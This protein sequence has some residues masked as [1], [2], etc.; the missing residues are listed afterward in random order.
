M[1]D[2][3]SFNVQN[4]PTNAQ[5]GEL[6]NLASRGEYC[7]ACLGSGQIANTDEPSPW[8]G[9]LALPPGSDLAVVM[10]FVQ[11]K[12]CGACNGRGL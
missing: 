12:T 3:K 2:P 11:P 4:R 1:I 7:P 10:G 5:L 6:F 8:L 9:W